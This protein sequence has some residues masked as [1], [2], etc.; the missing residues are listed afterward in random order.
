MSATPIFLVM[1]AGSP[2]SAFTSKHELK[3]YLRRWLDVFVNPLVYTFGG[4]GYAPTIMTMSRALGESSTLYLDEDNGL[5]HSRGRGRSSIPL[6]HA[7]SGP[8]ASCGQH[9]AP[10]GT[11]FKTPSEGP[12][13]T[14]VLR[15]Q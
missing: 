11:S 10:R 13:P 4:E 15:S 8:R 2:V 14:A 9:E 1:D 7:P 5:G 12:L 3:V 6:S